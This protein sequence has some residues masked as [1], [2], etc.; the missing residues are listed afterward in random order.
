MNKREAS[1]A[2][3]AVT[4]GTL[5]ATIAQNELAKADLC[6]ILA[7]QRADP[8]PFAMTKAADELLHTLLGTEEMDMYIRHVHGAGAALVHDGEAWGTK[9]YADGWERTRAAFA[10]SGIDLLTDP[11]AA[12]G[13][14]RSGAYC[15]LSVKRSCH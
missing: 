10:A 3:M 12:P 1:I 7:A 11:A 14:P 8:R 13:H 9:E 2:D 6:L 5:T 15:L 4:H